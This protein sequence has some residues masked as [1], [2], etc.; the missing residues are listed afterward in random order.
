MIIGQPGSGKSTLALLLGDKTG[1][2]VIHID[3]FHYRPGWN[4]RSPQEKT[5]LCRAAAAG[6][7]W[8]FEGGHS[9]AWPERLARADML[10]WLDLPLPRRLFRVIRRTLRYHGRS[11]PEMPEN[12]PERFDPEFFAYIWRTRHLGRA[13]ARA[14]YDSATIPRHRLTGPRDANRFL[15]QIES[16]SPA[17]QALD[18]APPGA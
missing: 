11:R 7:A 2:P 17:P 13:A 3:R 6:E 10:I 8:I 4:E 12:C 15:A 16:A 18:S 5:A 1:L 14:L 9:A